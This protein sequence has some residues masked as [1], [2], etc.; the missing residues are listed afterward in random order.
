MPT[1]PWHASALPRDGETYVTMLTFLPLKRYRDTP[2]FI[3]YVIRVYLQLKR[4]E[5]VVGFSMRSEPLKK[6]YWTLSAWNSH[7]AMGNYIHTPPHVDV[8]RSMQGYM[9]ATAF[10]SWEATS[11]DL[12]LSWDDALSRQTQ[13]YTR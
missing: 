7:Q 10:T 12:P 9:G 5:G 4:T 6:K 1:L 11:S 8:M 13:P 3:I 2:R